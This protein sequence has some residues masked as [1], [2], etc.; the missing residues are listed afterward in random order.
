MKDEKY[1]FVYF[2]EFIGLQ[3]IQGCN[4]SYTLQSHFAL[5]DVLHLIPE[6]VLI[7]GDDRVPG[8]SEVGMELG[9]IGSD[10]HVPEILQLAYD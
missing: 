9:M 4:L 6:N 1:S 5:E 3:K 10:L 2:S 7:S 8:I